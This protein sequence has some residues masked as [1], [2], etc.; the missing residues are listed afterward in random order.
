MKSL[1]YFREEDIR[2]VL[3]AIAIVIAMIGMFYA[4]AARAETLNATNLD[5]GASLNWGGG[6]SLD[7]VAS[8]N[9]GGG[10]SLN[11]GA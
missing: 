11:W 2:R 6:N 4:T 3:V 5:K 10:G 1:Y 7:T 8:L 9:W